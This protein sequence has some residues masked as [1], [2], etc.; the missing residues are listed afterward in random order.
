MDLVLMSQLIKNLINFDLDP[1]VD[2]AHLD[3]PV[4]AVA[5]ALKNFFATLSEPVVPTGFYE[6]IITTMG[7]FRFGSPFI[8]KY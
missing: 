7:K 8:V 6:E 4:N 1:H 2:F 3:I 5:T